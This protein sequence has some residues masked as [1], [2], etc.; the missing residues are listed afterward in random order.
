MDK[1]IGLI[2]IALLALSLLLNIAVFLVM[3]NKGGTTGLVTATATTATTRQNALQEKDLIEINKQDI[4]KCCSFINTEGKED[5]CY[6]L[7]KYS[8]SYCSEY[9]S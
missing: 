9:C 5:I 2:I 3:K 7:K 8:C 4:T 6:V 1:K